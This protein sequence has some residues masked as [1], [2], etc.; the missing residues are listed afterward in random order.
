M[1]IRKL[2]RNSSKK[3][4]GAKLS[5]RIRML[6]DRA[7][8]C[9]ESGRLSLGE[10]IC[11][12]IIEISPRI[13]EA[14]NLLGIIYEEQ[15]LIDEA[16]TVLQ[17][18]IELGGANANPYFNLGTILGQHGHYEKAA[19]ALRKGLS[20]SP[21]TPKARN[22]LGLALLNMGRLD[23]AVNSFEKAT[24]LDPH[25]GEAWFNLG[26]AYYCNGNL[27]ES[28]AAYQNSI[29]LI[30]DF[31]EAHYN[32]SI[33]LHDL[34][35]QPEA[36]ETLKRTIE[37]A[38]EHMAARHM[39]AALSGETPD[40]APEQFVTNLFDQ[41]ANQ[42]DVDLINRLEY[43]IPARLRQFLSAHIPDSIRFAKV[44][45]LGCGTGLSGQAFKDIA[46]YLAGIDISK[47]MLI[48]AREKDI[49]DE[50]LAGDVCEQVLRLPDPYDLFIAADVFI[51]IGNLGPIFSAVSSKTSPG[52]YYVFSIESA[53]KK[54]FILQSTGRYAHASQYI[55]KL[56]A[57]NDFTIIAQ[58]KAGIRKENDSWISGEIYLL[59]KKTA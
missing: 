51:Y 37:L 28:I 4:K 44:M 29:R 35:L 15:G 46:T 49:Y 12:Q 50:L 40:S 23:E 41:Y 2:K 43:T 36:R 45:D 27:Q 25:Y 56:A 57:V 3:N 30:P 48:K 18:S 32:L 58:E 7:T 31:I 10:N 34:N 59:Q 52:A 55:K 6:L 39:L 17:K 1:K 16:V 38:P 24:D 5:P 20:L 33:A 26:D 54:D 11:R 47:N 9:V 42:F 21:R 13:S 53:L 8:D 22:N 14:Y 19:A